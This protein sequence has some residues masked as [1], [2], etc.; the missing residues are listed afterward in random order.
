MCISV[1]LPIYHL[2]VYSVIHCGIKP[3]GLR[4][5]QH[6]FYLWAILQSLLMLLIHVKLQ[7]ACKPCAYSLLS[8]LCQ[9]CSDSLSLTP[10]QL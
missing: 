7:I 1:H 8:G 2:A 10:R 6:V 4:H 5:A 3:Q 9:R